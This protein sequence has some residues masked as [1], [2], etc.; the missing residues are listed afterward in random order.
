MYTN[1]IV[2]V[3]RP[4]KGIDAATGYPTESA[5]IT[6]LSAVRCVLSHTTAADRRVRSNGLSEF[7][8][9]EYPLLI[10]GQPTAGLLPGDIATITLDVS[11]AV[12]TFTINE[13]IFT[14]GIGECH[15]QATVERLKL[16]A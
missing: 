13:A 7:A 8:K 16:A 1:A 6:L 15:W 11:G 10:H 5:S 4:T 14:V 2:T 12:E 9:P 3:T